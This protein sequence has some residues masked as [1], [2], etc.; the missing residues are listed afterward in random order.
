[1]RLVVPKPLKAGDEIAV[2]LPARSV[3]WYELDKALDIVKQQGFKLSSKNA[4]GKHYFQYP[5]P[6]QERALLINEQ[7]QDSNI[8]L[9]WAGRG[10]LGSLPILDRVQWFRLQHNPK[11]IMGYSDITAILMH[12]WT[13]YRLVTIHGPVMRDVSEPLDL[14]ELTRKPPNITWKSH[15]VLNPRTVSGYLIGGNLSMIYSLVGS[16]SLPKNWHDII[17][18]IEEVDEY[19][20]HIERMLISLDRAGILPSLK[21][22]ILGSFTDIHDHDIPFGKTVFDI[23]EE[24]AGKYGYPIVSDFPVGHGAVNKP[25]WHGFYYSLTIEAHGTC[26]LADYNG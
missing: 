14:I 21:G 3:D 6:D 20:Y 19:L 2:F 25:F 5:L 10:G 22:L 1:M 12:L 16:N 18:L 13:N 9:M 24:V 7:L 8:T 26:Y 17:L 4:V 23:V 15:F 11:W